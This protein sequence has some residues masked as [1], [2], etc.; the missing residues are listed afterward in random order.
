MSGSSEGKQGSA[1]RM[2]LSDAVKEAEARLTAGKF[3][4]AEQL[5]NEILRQHPKQPQTVQVLAALA[6]RRGDIEGTVRV[7]R[8][9]LTGQSGDALALMNLCRVLRTQG[10]LQESRDAGEAA[11]K[12]G[13]VPA[14]I[15]DLGDTYAAL[16]EHDLALKTFELAVARSP[17]LARARLGLA[18]ALLMKGEFRSGWAE[19]EWRY[20]LPA[21]R[22]LLP[23]FPHATWNGMPLAASTLLVVCEQGFGDCVQFAR[24]LPLVAQRVARV[25]IGCGTELRSLLGTVGGQTFEAY[26]RWENLPP[27]DYQIAISSLPMVFGTTVDTIPA[28]VPYLTA[29]SAKAAVWRGR[30]EAAAEGRKKV[31]IV[32]QGR[33]SHPQDRVRSCGLTALAPLMELEG[34]LP[35]S[36][37]VGAGQADLAQHRLDARVFDAGAELKDFS[38]TAA[39]IAGLDCVVTIDSAI[40]HLTGALARPGFVMLSKA[41]EWRW[42]QGRSDTPWYPTLTLVRQQSAGDWG[43]VVQ[44]IAGMLR[45]GPVAS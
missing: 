32:W 27:F 12:F 45:A 4:A 41:G 26:E 36:L 1:R 7:L 40:A 3:E 33:P 42:M 35:V 21:T 29:D 34:V 10:R 15:A 38:D 22:D 25:V 30:L 9:S 20:K 23:K 44:R 13:T 16:G 24:Y 2:K 6:E 43:G 11:A 14:A 19:Y 5:A 17:Q 37:Q 18:H 28:Q 8:A 39:V 31:G